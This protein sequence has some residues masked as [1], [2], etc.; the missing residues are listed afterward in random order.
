MLYQL[1]YR[2]LSHPRAG[3]EPA[4]LRFQAEFC[5]WGFVDWEVTTRVY[6]DH[7]ALSTLGP[8]CGTSHGTS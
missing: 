4:T 2:G 1:S 6:H 5:V 7:S 8:S 3:L